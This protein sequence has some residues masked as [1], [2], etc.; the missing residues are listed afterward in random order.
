MLYFSQEDDQ[1]YFEIDIIRPARLQFVDVP[2]E[3]D[4]IDGQEFEMTVQVSGAHPATP[5]LEWFINTAKASPSEV[6]G[7]LDAFASGSVFVLIACELYSD[8]KHDDIL[9]F[10]I[11]ISWHL[12]NSR[13]VHLNK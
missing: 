11:L 9:Y 3:L 13:S 7:L 4:L 10:Y 5:V 12:N 2:R 1:K 8:Q 6:S